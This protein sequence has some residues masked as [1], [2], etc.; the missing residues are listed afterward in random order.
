MGWEKIGKN[1]M[2]QITGE[3]RSTLDDK[4]R[5]SLP[6]RL[7]SEI[8]G[9]SVIMTQGIDKCLWIFPPE[10][11]S[12]F[13]SK[14]TESISVFHARARMVQRRIIAPAQEIEIDKAGRVMI[15]QSLREFAGLTKECV[16]LGLNRYIEV[17]NADLYRKYWEENEADFQSASEEL[18]SILF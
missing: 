4:G 13:S 10:I 3:F 7:R 12:D 15:P 5:S 11:W 9:A 2:G 18:G 17:W 1:G 14:V 6:A 16:I 8:A